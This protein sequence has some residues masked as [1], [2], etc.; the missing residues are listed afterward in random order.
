MEH[1]MK[2]ATKQDVDSALQ[3]SCEAFGIYKKRNLRERAD[4]LR[5]IAV[6]IDSHS[7]ELIAVANRE[8]HL[9]EERLKTEL[10]R[11]L[12]QLRSYADACEE[13]T[14]LDIRIDYK[15]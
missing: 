4:F 6:E 3:L 9:G 1:T 2:E 13:G 7:A 10:K 14:W 12:F 5:T 11:T 8:T 15:L